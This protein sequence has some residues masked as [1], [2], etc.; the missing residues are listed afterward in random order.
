MPWLPAHGRQ[1]DSIHGAPPGCVTI[2][3]KNPQET[4]QMTF[5]LELNTV[6][7]RALIWVSFGLS[8][9]SN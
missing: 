2:V 4:P 9:G 3:I 8:V 5:W 7:K 1:A 6:P